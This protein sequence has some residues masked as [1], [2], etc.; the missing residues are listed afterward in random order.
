MKLKIDTKEI[1]V[2]LEKHPL[3]IKIR[4]E[5]IKQNKVFGN[6]ITM[7]TQQRLKNLK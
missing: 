6:I 1:I 7:T 4:E 2:N 5:L 3:L